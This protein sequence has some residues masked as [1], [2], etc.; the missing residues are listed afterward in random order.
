MA[1]E[2]FEK[3]LQMLFPKSTVEDWKKIAML[4]TGGKDP[5]ESL[6]WHGKD[7]LLFLPYYDS[8]NTA[9]LHYL[10]GVVT[11]AASA[12]QKRS[13]LNLPAVIVTDEHVANRLALEHLGQGANG[14]LFDLRNSYHTD[15]KALTEKIP[16]SSCNVFFQG[17]NEQHLDALTQQINGHRV[18]ATISSALFWESVPKIRNGASDL[19]SKNNIRGLGVTIK[20][21]SPAR[22]VAQA[23]ADGVRMIENFNDHNLADQVVSSICFSIPADACFLETAAKIKALRFLWFQILHAY[24]HT[25]YKLADVHIHVRSMVLTD[26]RYTPHENMLKAT[27]A[28]MAAIAGGCDSLTIEGQ[29]DAALF[30]R[31]SRNVSN[32]F[33]E[34]SFFDAVADPLAGAY[35]ADVITDAI[36]KKAWALFQQQANVL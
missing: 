21:A 23:L 33:R 6:S 13:W 14:V 1:K 30:R 3:Q 2:S 9:D 11:A 35:A 5:F 34:E 24:G 27:F 8:D 15:F 31:W 19:V 10:D 22:E 17:M 7:D 20:P 26:L 12:P 18:P 4:E 36:A 16:V 32:I 28:S 29:T 25:D